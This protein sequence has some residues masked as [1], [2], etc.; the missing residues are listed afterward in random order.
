MGENPFSDILHCFPSLTCPNFEST[1]PAHGVYHHIEP[2]RPPVHALPQRLFPEKLREACGQSM[3]QSM[4]EMGIIRTSSSPWSS[5]LHLMPK[6]SSEW[7][8]CDDYWRLNI[9]TMPDRYPVPHIQDFSAAPHHRAKIFS[10][11]NLIRGYHQIPVNPNDIPMTA[12]SMPFGL[13]E[14]IRMPFGLRNAGQTQLLEALKAYLSISMT[15]WLPAPIPSN[16]CVICA[17]SSNVFRTTVLWLD[18][19]SASLDRPNSIASATA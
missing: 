2:T 5:P 11:I 14:C 6:S 1:I 19:K 13:F 7:C 8:P 18:L 9:N 16:T 17:T 15:F 12:I 3:F 4:M 10:K